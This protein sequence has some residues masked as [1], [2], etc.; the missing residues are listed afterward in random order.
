MANIQHYFFPLLPFLLPFV[1]YSYWPFGRQPVSKSAITNYKKANN[2]EVE[3]YPAV[4]S[5]LKILSNVIW[6]PFGL[7]LCIVHL[8]TG[9]FNFLA[10]IFIVTIPI[11]L[12]NALGNFKMAEYL[13]L[14]LE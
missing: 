14:L 5:S 6:L 11:C 13:L 2:M 9:L 7:I 1:G 4:K 12:P 3:D 10:C 8:I